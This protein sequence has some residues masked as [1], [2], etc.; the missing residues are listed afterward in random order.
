MLRHLEADEDEYYHGIFHVSLSAGWGALGFAHLPGYTAIS[1][2]GGSHPLY[3]VFA[4]ELGHNLSSL[5]RPLRRPGGSSSY[6]PY[7]DGSIGAWGH[8]FIAGDEHGIRS[9]A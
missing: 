9:V 6:F 1:G 5:A 2:V 3:F 7:P 4:H 8:R